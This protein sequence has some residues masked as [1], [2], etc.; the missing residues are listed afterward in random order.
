MMGQLCRWTK[1][2]LR[3]RGSCYKFS[4]YGIKSH[5]CM[6]TTPSLSCSNKGVFCWRHGTN[7]VSTTWNWTV[8]PPDFLLA[9]VMAGHY[10]KIKM[11]KGVPGI[12][13][14]RFAEAF[15]IRH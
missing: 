10:Q 12:R 4:F 14:E 13:A 1:S 11:M 7:R 2:A 15:T 3:G 5:L 9:G 6:E 8:D